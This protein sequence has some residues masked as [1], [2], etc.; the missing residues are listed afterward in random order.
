MASKRKR[1]RKSKGYCVLPTCSRCGERLH[2][3]NAI[4]RSNG[5]YTSYC[6]DCNAEVA[7][8]KRYKNMPLSKRLE[9]IKEHERLIALIEEVTP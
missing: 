7:V 6:K 3:G 2:R 8:L 9:A 1:K 4:K 5:R